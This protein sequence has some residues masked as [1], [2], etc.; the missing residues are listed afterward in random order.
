M[1][2]GNVLGYAAGSY[3]KLYYIFPFSST[4]AWRRLLRQSQKLLLHRHHPPRHSHRHRAHRRERNSDRQA[5]GA[6]RQ[7]HSHHR[8]AHRVH[9]RHEEAD[10]DLN[11]RHFA[12][13][14]GWFPFILFD[15]DWMGKEVYG[16]VVGEG[17]AYDAGVRAGALGLMINSV[18]LGFMS[19]GLE[20]D[21]VEDWRESVVGWCE[22]HF[23]DRLALTVVV[24][25]MA[26]SY[27][28]THGITGSDTIPPDNIIAGC[29]GYFWCPRN[30]SSSD[31]QFTIRIGLHLF[32]GFRRWPRAFSGRVE[33]VHC[34]STDVCIGNQWFF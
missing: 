9:P 25:K 8:R 27:R 28:A 21:C 12:Q 24:S 33:L 13:L 23:G 10:V 29:F 11:A 30:S 4:I 32:Q 26:E 19:L 15:T 22:L 14:I 17:K 34:D 2:V 7:L 3:T 20:A 16:G 6:P 31:I 18:V 1:A 5:S